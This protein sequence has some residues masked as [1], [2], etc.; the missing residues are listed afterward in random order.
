MGNDTE[1]QPLIPEQIEASEM[2]MA[3]LMK[4]FYPLSCASFN[5][6]MLGLNH[7]IPY[8]NLRPS[9]L[10][11][12]SVGITRHGGAKGEGPH[13][14]GCIYPRMKFIVSS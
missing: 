11:H 14:E 7:Y 13:D 12:Q 2:E 10:A 3:H 8:K 9:A 5:K 6:T 1:P 4:Q